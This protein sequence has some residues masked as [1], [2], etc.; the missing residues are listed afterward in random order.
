MYNKKYPKIVE[1][2][3]SFNYNT[4]KQRLSFHFFLIRN[5]EIFVK[6]VKI[7]FFKKM[8]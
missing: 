6:E 8:K 7:N 3:I 5:L 4:I 1:S 2:S